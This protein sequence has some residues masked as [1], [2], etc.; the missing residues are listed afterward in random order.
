MGTPRTSRCFT[1]VAEGLN[2]LP[3]YDVLSAWPIIGEGPNLVSEHDARLAM[4][5]RGK[6][7]HY[8]LREIRVR[9][10]QALAQ[11]CGAPGVWE[12]TLRMAQDVRGVMQRVQAQLP[13]GFPSQI[14]CTVS[15]GVQRQADQF[16]HEVALSRPLTA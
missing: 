7:V 9:H 15:E 8:K 14:W 13:S 2:S 3:L 6:S 12:A 4:A 16:L 10:W 1:D 11:R 5:L